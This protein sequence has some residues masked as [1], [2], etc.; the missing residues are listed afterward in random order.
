[1]RMLFAIPFLSYAYFVRHKQKAPAY[2][3]LAKLVKAYLPEHKR[4]FWTIRQKY[5]VG[6]T[7]IGDVVYI[8]RSDGDDKGTGGIIAKC[9]IEGPEEWVTEWDNKYWKVEPNSNGGWGVPLDINELRLKRGMILRTDLVQDPL[10]KNLRVIRMPA[11]TNYLLNEKEAE[12]LDNLWSLN[13]SGPDFMAD[14]GIP[15]IEGKTFYAW[16]RK[17]ERNRELVKYVKKKTMLEKGELRCIVC[18]FSFL[19]TYGKTGENFIEAH[20]TKAISD[21]GENEETKPEDIALVCSN[22]HRMLHYRRL[23]MDKLKQLLIKT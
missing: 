12:L 23:T 16:H 15:F 9:T 17:R 22:C 19:E 18:D 8:W 14:E 2:C 4:I 11:E 13:N 20:H 10:L 1:M 21:M 3:F 6:H 7:S 5:F